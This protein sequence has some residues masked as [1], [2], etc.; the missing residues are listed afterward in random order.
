MCVARVLTFIPRSFTKGLTAQA[1]VRRHHEK[2]KYARGHTQFL[3]CHT[4]FDCRKT[5]AEL[6]GTGVASP[7]LKDYACHLWYYWERL[8]DPDLHIDRFLRGAAAGQVVLVTGGS[9]GIGLAAT[10]KLTRP[11]PPPLFVAAM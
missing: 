4:R 8:L 3:N 2:P 9:S 1:S 7:N 11:V 6:Q 5:L 10:H